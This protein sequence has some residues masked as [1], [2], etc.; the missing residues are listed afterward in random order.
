MNKDQGAPNTTS[1]AKDVITVNIEE[2]MKQS[3][4][5]YAMSVIVGRALPD[6]R[7][8][9]KPVHRRVL[10]AMHEVA[11]DWNKAFKKSA[12]IVGDVMG[13]YHP[14]GDNAIYDTIVRM[15]QNFSLRKV[16][17]D[18][19]GNFGSVDGDSAAAMRYT[20]MRMSKIAHEMLSDIEKETVNFVPNYDGSEQE[21][22]V[23]PT[24]FPNLLL[25]GSS[26]IAV[27]MATSIPP[28]NLGEIITACL[29][30]LADPEITI[31]EIIKLV[32]APDFPTAAIIFGLKDV[33]EGYRTGRGRVV[34]RSRTHIE[35]IGK[36]REAIIIDELPYQVN[37]AKLCE[38]IA[39]LVKEKTVEGISEIRDESDKS[40]MR[41]V[42]ELKRGENSSVILN[43]L[44]K[45]TP[46][47]DSFGINM[48]S[49]VN[50][51][52]KLLNLKTMIAEFIAHR[53]EIVTRR[54]VFELKKA[55]ERGHLLE[56]L[57]I[58]LVN[59]D[60]M[61]AMIKIANTPANAK[62]SL[63]SALWNQDLVQK[64]Y[65]QVQSAK[66]KPDWLT[67][68]Q[69]MQ[70]AGYRLSDIQTQGILDLKLQRLTALEQNKITAEYQEIINTIINLM[71]ILANPT[72]INQIIEEELVG[73]K[74]Q[75]DDPRRS[76][77][78]LDSSEINVEDLIKPRDMVV[79]LSREGY[80]KTQE[81]NEYRTQ[82]RGGRGKSATNIKEDDYISNLFMAHTHD[83]ILCFSTSG[84]V[85]WLKVYNLPEGSRATRGKPI[86]NLLSLQSDEKISSILSVKEFTDNQFI[87]MATKMGVVKKTK[88]SVF[89]RPNAKGIAAINLDQGD[90]LAGVALTD[91][92][93]EVM[94][95]S[96]TGKAV[97]FNESEVRDMGRSARGV[98][99]IKLKNGS[100]VVSLLTTDDENAQVLTATELGYGKRT[101]VVEYRLASR[102]TQGV[103]AIK[104]TEK[105][106][107]LVSALLVA[108]N[109]QIMLITDGG[110]L[111]RTKVDSIRETGRSAQGVKLIDLGAGEK[112]VDISLVV[113][114]E[115]IID[116]LINLKTELEPELN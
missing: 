52:P 82:R 61:I 56:G 87:F 30:L 29:A 6:V 18:G 112:M 106:G 55:K 12:R 50:G 27:G 5:D 114:R 110:V 1:F 60:A 81:I 59:V 95:F 96:D 24:K 4:L 102:A 10:F 45:L 11:N 65:A 15:A 97:R 62:K 7:D 104:V 115:E 43:N 70:D 37:K 93:Q 109:D 44:F 26:G 75:F 67:E 42:I 103:I 14:H 34:I 41:V 58:A 13:K 23:L 77:I 33:H 108:D 68:E 107:K 22:V 74:Q 111:I 32:P 31:E 84:R 69:G 71:D 28:H 101:Q 57:A 86:V 49:L 39:D 99:G 85:Y 40:G 78:V 91:G 72:R 54:T 20:E 76:E 8:G 105:N 2:E 19:Q 89:S 17:I 98:K 92:K 113:E 116:N 80:I 53:R 90:A 51:Q 21:P 47:Q 9:L 73:I 48:V 46:M 64:M 79:T 25:N 100:F 38:K 83:F 88:L 63:I 3:Y 36:D 94:I 16:L 66:I 35:S